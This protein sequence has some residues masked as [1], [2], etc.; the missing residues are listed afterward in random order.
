MTQG[1]TPLSKVTLVD[2][3][4][5][6]LKKYILKN[7]YYS[8]KKLP[9]TTELAKKFGVGMPTLREAIKKLETIG[10]LSVRHGSGIF[11]GDQINNIILANPLASHESPSKKHLLDLIDARMSVEI[12]TAEL[13]AKNANPDNIKNMEK[14]LTEAKNNFDNEVLLTQA[15]MAFHLAIAAASG[16]VVFTQLVEVVTKLFRLEQRLIIDIFKHKD[17][18][19]IQHVEIFDAIKNHDAQ[20]AVNLMRTH[21]ENVR[22]AIRAWKG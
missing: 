17:K 19:Y 20:N 6:E 13:A 4:A 11:V 12:S 14:L 2:N 9:S 18:D 8:G 5:L 1:I 10:A 15:N 3:L 7:S 21:L 16:N 22:D